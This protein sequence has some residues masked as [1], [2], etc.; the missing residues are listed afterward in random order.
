MSRGNSWLVLYG[1]D[2]IL[3]NKMFARLL[4]VVALLSGVPAMAS[5][6]ILSK[7]DQDKITVEKTDKCYSIK[8]PSNVMESGINGTSFCMGGV[9]TIKVPA[10]GEENKSGK[11]LISYALTQKEQGSKNQEQLKVRQMI[12]DGWDA[13]VRENICVNIIS[14]LA[15]KLCQ[16]KKD[17]KL[18]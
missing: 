7:V 9:Y 3:I 8:I 2:F 11:M 6:K 1:R 10:E 15:G 18:G 17:P 12:I 4:C 16:Q 14:A 5:E 13:D